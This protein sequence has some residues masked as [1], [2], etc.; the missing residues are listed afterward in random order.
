MTL[1][2]VTYTTAESGVVLRNELATPVTLWGGMAAQAVLAVDVGRVHGPSDAFLP[3]RSLVGLAAGL[4]GRSGA[5]Q[6]ETLLAV[7]LR[8]PQG[9]STRPFSVYAS[10][11]HSF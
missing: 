4:R 11:T 7:P 8:Y 10:V 2:L 6:F 1:T 9:F 5:T 3:G